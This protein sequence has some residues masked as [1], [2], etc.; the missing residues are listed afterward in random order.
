MQLSAIQPKLVWLLLP[1]LALAASPSRRFSSTLTSGLNLLTPQNLST[2]SLGRA[3]YCKPH[4]PDPYGPPIPFTSSLNYTFPKTPSLAELGLNEGE[5]E[6]PFDCFIELPGG[7]V[8]FEIKGEIDSGLKIT[9]EVW[10]SVTFFNWKIGVY[11]CELLDLEK[12]PCA[13]NINVKYLVGQGGLYAEDDEDP[14]Y[15]NLCLVF[16]GT[17]H[18]PYTRITK[19]KDFDK[20]FYKFPRDPSNLGEV[21]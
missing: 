15:V 19:K 1:V 7:Y 10:V 8:V 5:G 2:T 16:H 13:F 18:I 6:W 3:A 9:F 11:S 17:L 4:D 12:D 20:C 14:K 21:S